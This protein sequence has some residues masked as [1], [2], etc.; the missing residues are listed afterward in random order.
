MLLFVNVSLSSILPELE[1]HPTDGLTD[2]DMF[3]ALAAGQI[4]IYPNP[5][6]H[7]LRW[8]AASQKL[9]EDNRFWLPLKDPEAYANLAPMDNGD[10][11]SVTRSTTNQR[12]GLFRKKPDGSYSLD[13]EPFRASTLL[14]KSDPS[15]TDIGSPAAMASSALI[16]A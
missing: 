16:R 9:V 2:G 11:W 8:D 6:K 15:P 5:A 12:Q 14:V 13:E 1:L 10:I 4:F 7:F 3:L